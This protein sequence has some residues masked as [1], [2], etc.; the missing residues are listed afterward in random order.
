M[1]RYNQPNDIRLKKSMKIQ[2]FIQKG[3]WKI[4]YMQMEVLFMGRDYDEFDE[5]ADKII[6]AAIGI[7]KAAQGAE[8]LY[9]GLK[10]TARSLR[11]PSSRSSD[12][13]LD[14]SDDDDY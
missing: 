7:A 2:A 3:I 11:D 10:Q 12:Y 4:K 9:H 14:Y 13:Y 5:I 1:I 6:G 8:D